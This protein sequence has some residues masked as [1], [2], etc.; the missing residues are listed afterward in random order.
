L[1]I[2]SAHLAETLPAAGKSWI[3][4]WLGQRNNHNIVLLA[5]FDPVYQGSSSSMKAYLEEVAKRG[6]I[7][8][9]AKSEE[10]PDYR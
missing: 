7:E 9:L 1:I 8:F 4:L 3:D 5:L 2:V 10:A 6:G